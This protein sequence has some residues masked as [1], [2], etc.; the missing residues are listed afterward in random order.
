VRRERIQRR[1]VF[2]GGI[3]VAHGMAALQQQRPEGA[4]VFKW[5]WRMTAAVLF[6]KGSPEGLHHD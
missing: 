1:Q 3:D 6:M 2:Q 5:M 4:Q